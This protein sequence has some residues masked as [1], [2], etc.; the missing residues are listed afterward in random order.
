VQRLWPRVRR[1]ELAV[2]FVALLAAFAVSAA[3]ADFKVDDGPCPEP[4][5]GG[6]VL[7]CPSAYVGQPYTLQ[8]EA[9]DGCAPYNWFEVLNGSLPAG[10]TMTRAG[11]IS[12]TPTGAGLGDFWL[13][14]HDLTASEGG[15]SWCNADDQSQKEFNIR[16]NPGLAIVNS[17]IAPGTVGELYSVSLTAQR[18]ESLTPLAGQDVQ[19][20]WAVQAGSLPAGISLSPA[21][22]L[23]GTPTAEG[24]FQFTVLAQS[25]EQSTTT[26]YTLAVRQPVVLKS[27]FGTSKPP[28]AEVGIR[29]TSAP[30][31]TGGNQTYTWS[32]SSGALPAGVSIN[33]MNGTISGSPQAA[34]HFAF[35]LTATDGEGRVATVNAALTVSP[36]LTIK[37][38]RLKEAKR[39][40][41][42]AA[43]LTTIGGVQPVKWK[44][45]SGKLPLGVRLATS[46]GTLV[47]TPRRVGTFRVTVQARDLL[48]GMSQKTLVLRVKS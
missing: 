45:L 18:I 5:G 39:G 17:S 28:K 22:V 19:A 20:A 35:G 29:F 3:S 25:A 23:A 1:L 36:K 37:T 7:Q 6:P 48:G 43:K 33:A 24:S 21:G 4:P 2:A 47:G 16:V 34:G 10:L 46:T 11:L 8:I 40:R 41:A 32:I 26:T 44:T 13:G 31:A 27:S 14:V 30:T 15:P 42:Y 9:E 38:V 12:G